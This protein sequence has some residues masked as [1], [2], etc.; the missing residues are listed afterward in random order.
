MPLLVCK[1]K[2]YNLCAGHLPP[3]DVDRSFQ[4]IQVSTAASLKEKL[5]GNMETRGFATS[6]N[7]IGESV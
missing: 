3:R 1:D 7:Q 6:S 4:V 5:L 2:G